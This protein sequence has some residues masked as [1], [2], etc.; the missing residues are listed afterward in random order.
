MRE[1]HWIPLDK[2]A[3]DGAL[4]SLSQKFNEKGG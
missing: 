2:M 1:G 3:V 4:F